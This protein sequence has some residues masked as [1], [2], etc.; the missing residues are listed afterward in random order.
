MPQF[1]KLLTIL[2]VCFIISLGVSLAKEPIAQIEK[3]KTFNASYYVLDN[4][5]QVVIIP[6]KRVPAITHMVWYKAGAADELRGRSG[7]AHFMEHLMFKG[8][9]VIGGEDLT[10]GAFSQDIKRLGGNDNAFTCL[11]YTS[12]SPRD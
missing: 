8:S 4:G 11:L 10:D 12:P 3:S 9:P 5:M 1:F 6:S 7:I 2:S